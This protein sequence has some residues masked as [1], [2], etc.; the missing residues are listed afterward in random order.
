MPASLS[1][2]LLL[3][4]DLGGVNFSDSIMAGGP[5]IDALPSNDTAAGL[6]LD[7]YYNIHLPALTAMNRYVT[8]VWYAVGYTGNVLAFAVW[9]Q[10]RMR[11]SSGCYLAALAV[12][13]FL[14]LMLH[15]VYTLQTSFNVM[16]L[17]R[18]FVC[19]AFPVVFY[20]TQYLSP[21]LVLAFSVE[22]S[23]V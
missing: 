13:D 11:H 6:T 20:A 19:E 16:A 10:P 17:Q 23:V 2:L 14:F 8:L 3:D 7:E 12:A 5:S 18:H 9:I 4:A 15:L 1:D 22:R 21:L